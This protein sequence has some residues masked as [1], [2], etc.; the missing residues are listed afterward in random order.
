MAFSMNVGMN[1][2]LQLWTGLKQTAVLAP[3]QELLQTL[4]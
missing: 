1:I 3:S 2:D 4:L